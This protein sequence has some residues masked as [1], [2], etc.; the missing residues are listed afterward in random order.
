MN[1]VH[2]C[3]LAQ[4]HP[5]LCHPM[6]CSPPAPLSTGLSRQEYWSRLPSPP[7]GELPNPGIKPTSIMCPAL[8]GRFFTIWG[9]REAS[10]K[11]LINPQNSDYLRIQ[12]LEFSSVSFFSL[13]LYFIFWTVFSSVQFSSVTQSC[14]TLCDPMNHRHARPP[15]PSPTPGVYSNSCSLSQWC[16]PAI[17][18][19]VVPFCSCPQPLPAI[20]HTA[21][22]STVW[23]VQFSGFQ[24]IYKIVLCLP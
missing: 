12:T 5:A 8:A 18:S 24:Y 13:L 20:V 10:L 2:T 15:C 16:H 1:V 7:P 6:G 17:S 22:N 19:S 4:L 9:P 11:R 23:G 14:P 21:Y 3:L